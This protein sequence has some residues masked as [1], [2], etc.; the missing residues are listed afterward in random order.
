[1]VKDVAT[2]GSLFTVVFDV[3][4][5]PGRRDERFG[6]GPVPV[7]LTITARRVTRHPSHIRPRWR[8]DRRAEPRR[9]GAN[10]SWPG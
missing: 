8:A 9:G 10:L 5:S 1:M 3:H 4:G 6:S 7:I 2:K